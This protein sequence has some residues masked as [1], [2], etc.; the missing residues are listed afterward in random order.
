MIGLKPGC[1]TSAL[2]AVTLFAVPP[3][4]A[5]RTTFNPVISLGYIY[6]DNVQLVG[7]DGTADSGFRLG[8]QL[9]V[10]RQLRKGTLSFTYSPNF[11]KYEDFSELDNT[12]HR[13]VFNLATQPTPISEL[14]LST[15][16]SR[17]QDQGDPSQPDDDI[18]IGRRTERERASFDLS[19]RDRLSGRFLW[20][21]STGY[22]ASSFK[23]IENFDPGATD[24][25]GDRNTLRG[26]VDL[27]RVVS[28]TTNFGVRIGYG[29]FELD[30]GDDEE[31]REL[32]L[33]LDHVVGKRTNLAVGLG[34][35]ETEVDEASSPGGVPGKSRTGG[36]G[37]LILTRQLRKLS[38][39]LGAVRSATA[40]GIIEG[41]STDSSVYFSLGSSV[42][43]R[44]DWT[45]D[46]RYS[47][48]EPSDEQLATIDNAALGLTLS[49]RLFRRVHLRL[50]PRYTRQLGDD[51]GADSLVLQGGFGLSWAPLEKTRLGRG[52]G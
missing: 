18:F 16:F 23:D 7:E 14:I 52:G 20:G 36:Q 47:R 45:V 26:S 21:F 32:S 24:P 13:L 15:A 1:W 35:F 41:T 51:A 5:Q 6:I 4:S 28:R 22:S 37:F 2:L 42:G 30:R 40:G 46:S 33:I 31:L 9:P 34:V 48:R 27:L 50:S 29:R 11:D 17:T 25:I 49:L 8:L 19:Y 12:G 38:L 3:L 44:W 43:R 10:V 39:S